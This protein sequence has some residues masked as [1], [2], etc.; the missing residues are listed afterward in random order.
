MMRREVVVTLTRESAER[1]TEHL[2]FDL[3]QWPNEW[4][5]RLDPYRDTI[6]WVIPEPE[7]LIIVLRHPELLDLEV[8]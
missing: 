3:S 2:W 7:F 5:Q 4:D 1:M 8:L 6:T